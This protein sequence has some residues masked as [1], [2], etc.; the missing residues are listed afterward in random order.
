M[1]D[2]Q[3]ENSLQRGMPE[4]YEETPCL[5]TLRPLGLFDPVSCTTVHA[6]GILSPLEPTRRWSQNP[7]PSNLAAC[8]LWCSDLYGCSHTPQPSICVSALVLEHFTKSMTRLK[9]SQDNNNAGR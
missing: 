1:A 4:T 6:S 9:P 8:L 3:E 5:L 2:R 7:R